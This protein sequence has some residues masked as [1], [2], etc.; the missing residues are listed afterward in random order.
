MGIDKVHFKNSKIHLLENFLESGICAKIR[1][2]YGNFLKKEEMFPDGC[3]L[4]T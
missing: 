3:W 1:G 2:I 4:K